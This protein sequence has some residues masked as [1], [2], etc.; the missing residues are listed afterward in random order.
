MRYLR[1][2]NIPQYNDKATHL[3]QILEYYKIASNRK[4]LPKHIVAYWNHRLAPDLDSIALV[5][6]HCNLC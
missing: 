1:L 3:S 4:M 6:I 2:Q 5:G